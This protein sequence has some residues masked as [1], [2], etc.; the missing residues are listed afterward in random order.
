MTDHELITALYDEAG[1]I[2]YC[3]GEGDDETALA[4]VRFVRGLPE[5]RI[6]PNDVRE[7]TAGDYETSPRWSALALEYVFSDRDQEEHEELVIEF[8]ATLTPAQRARAW[9][10][11]RA[12]AT[13]SRL[14]RSDK[15]KP[16]FDALDERIEHSP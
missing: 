13:S 9:S 5:T 15:A 3:G 14:V 10:A 6:H 16:I 8:F 7:N 4:F 11:V 12:R 2:S 1:V